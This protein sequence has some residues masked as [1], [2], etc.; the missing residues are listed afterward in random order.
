MLVDEENISGT[1]SPLCASGG[2]LN[3]LHRL[4]QKKKNLHREVS[5]ELDIPSTVLH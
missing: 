5:V 4:C 2:Y 3:N 1:M